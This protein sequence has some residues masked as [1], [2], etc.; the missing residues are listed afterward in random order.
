M[1]HNLRDVEVKQKRATIVGQF[2]VRCAWLREQIMIVCGCAVPTED[3]RD[4]LAVL[5]TKRHD[6][7]LTLMKA[8]RQPPKSKIKLIEH[9]RKEE[10]EMLRTLP[11]LELP[12][13]T[14]DEALALLMGWDGRDETALKLPKEYATTKLQSNNF[15]ENKK[16]RESVAAKVA[17]FEPKLLSAVDVRLKRDEARGRKPP[18]IVSETKALISGAKTLGSSRKDSKMKLLQK[19]QGSKVTVGSIQVGQ[20]TVKRKLKQELTTKQRRHQQLK[21]SRGLL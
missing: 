5:F 18:A 20:G 12:Q 11:G 14:T 8:Q 17:E 1:R 13:T 16:K 21:L 3:E 4:A 2:A 10:S 9:T 6:E 19:K 7:E 15:E